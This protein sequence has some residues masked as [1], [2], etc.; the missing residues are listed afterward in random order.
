MTDPR[1]QKSTSVRI[2]AV[3]IRAGFALAERCAP[4]LGGRYAAG[5]WLTVPP[6][7]AA[8]PTAPEPA[9]GQEF[10]IQVG[11]GTVRGAGY[12]TGPVVYL[13]HGWGG[14]GAQLSAFVE[15]LRRAGFRVVRF[16]APS[17][18]RSDPGA[19][20]RGRTHG[21]EFA[22]AL[23][24]VMQRFGPADTVIAHSMGVLPS[25]LV[26]RA[27][28][29]VGRL[30]LIA[31]VRDLDGH[32]GRFATLVGMG[33]RTRRAMDHRIAEIIGEPVAGMDVRR[34]AEYTG[35][36]PLLVVHD[37]ADRETWHAHS[38]E[39]AERWSGPVTMISTEGLGHRRILSDPGVVDL[40]TGFVG[41]TDRFA[42]TDRTSV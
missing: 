29:P 13:M 11:D 16:D 24:A 1:K 40:V 23:A 22:A 12:G 15:P 18:G 41:A 37:R 19:C 26:Q 38:V 39:L 33:P 35:P 30:A 34:L 31:P 20:G 17:H 8:L 14:T 25:L 28:L 4:T 10:A 9:G 27:G 32:L 3:A 42:R 36:I 5:R 6:A 7:P 2:K 21:V